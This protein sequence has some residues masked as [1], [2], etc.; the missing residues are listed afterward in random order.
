[1]CLKLF[2]I[3][4]LYY[5]FLPFLAEFHRN[6][7]ASSDLDLDSTLSVNTLNCSRADFSPRTSTHSI[8]LLMRSIAGRLR[9]EDQAPRG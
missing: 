2:S 7:P 8:D 4:S 6:P 1:M 3:L 9:E 5:F